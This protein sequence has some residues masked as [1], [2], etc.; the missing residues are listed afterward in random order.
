MSTCPFHHSAP[1][2][3]PVPERIASLPTMR[4]YPVPWF[5]DKVN[6]E[7][8]FRVMDGRK[9]VRAVKESLCW[10]CGGKLGKFKTFILGPMCGINRTIS[11]PPSHRE[12]ARYAAQHCPFLTIPHM[13]RREDDMT[14]ENEKK[15]A[16]I[17]LKRNP[18]AVC[19]WT[20]KTYTPFSDGR[21]GVLFT[22]P[23]PESLEWY[24]EGRTATREEVME[25][26]DTGLPLLRKICDEQGEVEGEARGAE[27]HKALDAQIAAFQRFLPEEAT[28]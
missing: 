6:G 28:A 19:L 11:E 5:V 15:V 2:A 12:C 24:A 1:V 13:K 10:T 23:D 21:G 18:G 7:Y 25:S 9:L 22:F 8:D 4:G 17:G 20:V 14:R 3:P 26:I 16:G 27:A